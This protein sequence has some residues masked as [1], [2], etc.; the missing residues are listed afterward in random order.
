M[1]LAAWLVSTTGCATKTNPEKNLETSHSLTA[2][3]PPNSRPVAPSHPEAETVSLAFLR[4]LESNVTHRSFAEGLERFGL[5]QNININAAESERLPMGMSLQ[6]ADAEHPLAS[7]TLNCAA[8]EV[9]TFLIEALASTRSTLESPHAVLEFARRFQKEIGNMQP[10]EVK[11]AVLTAT[12]PRC[13]E[14]DID[15]RLGD[16][17]GWLT[18][19]V[20]R[21]EMQS[22]LAKRPEMAA[23]LATIRQNG[24]DKH[25]VL[26]AYFVYLQRLTDR[27]SPTTLPGQSP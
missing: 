1:L 14:A 3:R 2:A 16:Q 25:W 8:P 23:K 4:A 10:A 22:A 15:R 6:P 17:I 13:E 11:F 7:I 19:V 27:P 26:R 18:P 5:L 20:P 12:C 21:P 24:R 9:Q